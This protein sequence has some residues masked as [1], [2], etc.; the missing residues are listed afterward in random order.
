MIGCFIP[1]KEPEGSVEF[2]PTPDFLEAGKFKLPKRI[3]K[4]IE[5]VGS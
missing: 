3:R 4:Q 5:E 1:K 2:Y